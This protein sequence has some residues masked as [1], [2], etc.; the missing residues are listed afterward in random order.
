MYPSIY[1]LH[2]FPLT[3]FLRPKS[4]L[5]ADL[6]F[7]KSPQW[8]EEPQWQK[9]VHIFQEKVDYPLDHP[10]LTLFP[11]NAT[12]NPVVKRPFW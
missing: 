10:I 12:L 5:E 7:R 3:M 11:Q 9:T 2:P 8:V 6:F 4:D 1:N